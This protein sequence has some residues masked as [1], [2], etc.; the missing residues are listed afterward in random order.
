MPPGT[1]PAPS[2]SE[3]FASRCPFSSLIGEQPLGRTQAS[4]TGPAR[5]LGTGQAGC[6][7]FACRLAP[8]KANPVQYCFLVSLSQAG[9]KC[10]APPWKSSRTRYRMLTGVSLATYASPRNE[11]AMSSQ[12]GTAIMSPTQP[13]WWRP[14]DEDKDFYKDIIDN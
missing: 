5:C 10:G 9:L 13:A 4:I 6:R 1:A 3:G 8:Q 12:P 11:P 7:I 14:M 2:R